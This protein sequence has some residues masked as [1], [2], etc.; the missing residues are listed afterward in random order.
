MSDVV[1][2]FLSGWAL[3]IHKGIADVAPVWNE[4][5]PDI[6]FQAVDEMLHGA[7]ERLQTRK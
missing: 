6:Q 7:W 2:P 4:R 1:V 3:G 5:F